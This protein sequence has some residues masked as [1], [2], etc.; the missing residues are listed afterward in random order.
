[1]LA[2]V[3]EGDA[4]A[5]ICTSMHSALHAC[6]RAAA[7]ARRW[8]A[9]GACTSQA[10]QDLSRGVTETLKGNECS[11]FRLSRRTDLP[12]KKWVS[13]RRP[14]IARS[15]STT[16][17]PKV[18]CGS[19]GLRRTVH[20]IQHPFFHRRV[21]RGEGAMPARARHPPSPSFPPPREADGGKEIA[22]AI[23]SLWCTS[24]LQSHTIHA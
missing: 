16:V 12:A 14:A 13:E 1:M 2:L 22:H 19:G 10:R 21:W 11:T 20:P 6:A 15:S 17:T 8:R 9:I 4:R 5:H 3:N 23:R 7:C 24:I 18:A